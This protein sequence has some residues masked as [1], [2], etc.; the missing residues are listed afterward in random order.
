MSTDSVA[1]NHITATSSYET[2][3]ASGPTPQVGKG[4]YAH[5]ADLRQCLVVYVSLGILAVALLIVPT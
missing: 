5:A 4:T 3:P 1:P 2:P